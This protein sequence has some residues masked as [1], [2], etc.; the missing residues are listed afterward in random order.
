MCFSL[1]SANVAADDVIPQ[2]SLENSIILSS[3]ATDVNMSVTNMLPNAFQLDDFAN[4]TPLLNGVSVENNGVSAYSNSAP[5]AGLTLIVANPESI[6]N[7]KATTD[8]ILYWVWNDGENVY[9]YDPDGDEIANYNISGVNEYVTGNVSLGDEVVGFAT[10]ITEAGPHEL[11]YYVTDSNGNT[12]NVVR[13]TIEIEPADGN[14]RPVCSLKV[15]TGPY[16]VNKNVVFNWSD[17]YDEDT[18]D[19]LSAVR[20]R[21]YTDAGYELVTT[22]SKYYVTSDNNG[23]TLRFSQTGTYTVMVSI[24]DN[25][26]AWS[27]WIGG[28]ISVEDGILKLATKNW[29]DSKYVRWRPTGSNSYMYHTL[30]SRLGEEVYVDA[31]REIKLASYSNYKATYYN[32]VMAPIV[33]GTYFSSSETWSSATGNPNVYTDPY[34]G[35]KTPRSITQ[36]EIDTLENAG[37]D[38]YIVYNPN[39]LEIIDFNCPLNPL[40]AYKWSEVTY[41]IK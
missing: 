14:K 20:V 31:A 4:T 24:S 7:G 29:S 27:N 39:T 23:I 15:I 10:Q 35:R 9:T 30:Y 12:S 25:H 38:F 22:S 28:T 8:T 34:F 1:L 5:I 37:E 13:Y 2:T 11:I 33:A 3:E 40:I 18:D 32:V 17:S 16:Y 6:V 21:V 41:V 36:S 26:N 19:T